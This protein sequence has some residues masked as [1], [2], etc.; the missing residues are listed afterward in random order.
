MMKDPAMKGTFRISAFGLA[1]L[2]A[3]LGG[4]TP[5]AAVARPWTGFG[6]DARAVAAELPKGFELPSADIDV[7]VSSLV[8]ADVDADGDLDIV[9]AGSSASPGIFV[10]LND[11]AG[12]LTRRRP[13]PVKTVGAEPAAPTVERRQGGTPASIQPDNTAV[14]ISAP[15]GRLTLP[16]APHGH[17]AAGDASSATC[18]A[19]RSRAPPALA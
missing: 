2:V 13:A 8:T 5:L 16:E 18:S 19:L 3:L 14:E 11:G 17:L 4:R 10:W 12:R 6:F 7:E 15:I 9:A 1:A